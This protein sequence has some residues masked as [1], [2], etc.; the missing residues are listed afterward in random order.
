M[1]DAPVRLL[2][3]YCE[4]NPDKA[5]ASCDVPQELTNEQIDAIAQ[6]PG[7]AEEQE[8]EDVSAALLA[9]SAGRALVGRDDVKHPCAHARELEAQAHAWCTRC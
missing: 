2:P 5:L 3:R 1:L 4:H 6:D 7:A 8:H 9:R